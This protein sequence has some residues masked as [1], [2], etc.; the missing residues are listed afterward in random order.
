MI[1]NEVIP[2]DPS[3]SKLKKIFF[4]SVFGLLNQCIALGTY[5]SDGIGNEKLKVLGKI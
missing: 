2:N 3:D 1:F 4:F 5:A